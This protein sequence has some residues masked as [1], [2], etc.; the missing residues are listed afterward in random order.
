M[1]EGFAGDRAPD[2]GPSR[3]GYGGVTA[4]NRAFG[5]ARAGAVSLCVARSEQRWTVKTD[6][7][8]STA[9][10]G[11]PVSAPAAA[12]VSEAIDRIRNRR[13]AR[14]APGPAGRHP[15]LY[16]IAGEERGP[17]SSLRPCTPLSAAAT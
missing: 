16:D 7:S 4:F 17:A 8:T 15:V 12:A 9:A 6:T 10:P 14:T 1:L 11:H 13:E 3:S 5:E 2:G